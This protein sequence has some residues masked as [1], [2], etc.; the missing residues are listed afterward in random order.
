[1]Q[2]WKIPNDFLTQTERNF[3]VAPEL[4][5]A[6]DINQQYSFFKRVIILVSA[7]M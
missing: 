2:G 4:S 6:C 5:I 3:M 1:M 7:G